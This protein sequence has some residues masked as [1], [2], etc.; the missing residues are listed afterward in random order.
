[1]Q[2]VLVIIVFLFGLA[3][4][5][6]LNV[7]IYRLPRRQ[8]LALPR[9]FC[10]RCRTPI[11]WYDNIPVLSYLILRGRCRH[12]GGKI[13][14]RYPLVELVTGFIF[15]AVHLRVLNMRQ[16][17]FRDHAIYLS[18]VVIPFLWYFTAS[19]IALSLI[20]WEHK[21]LPDPITYPLLA[22]GLLFAI[23]SPRHFC[24]F[25]WRNIAAPGYLSGLKYSVLGL[26]IGGGSLWLIGAAGKAVFKKEAMG[27]GDVKLMAA[28]GAWQ[29]WPMTLLAVFLGS[30]LASLV[31]VF[32]LV[33]K[34]ARWGTK[35]PFGPYLVLGSLLTL[36]FGQEIIFWYLGFYLH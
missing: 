29:G 34:Q 3:I 30:I 14:I 18:L 21:I 32:L 12:C 36:F 15:V 5:S 17:L 16:C 28:V 10:P 27:F 8:S 13:S 6:F 7:C 26:A 4:G 1:M 24:L 22:V 33:S 25:Q 20:D 11:A 19:L 23:I 9:S 35:I 2:I 31:G